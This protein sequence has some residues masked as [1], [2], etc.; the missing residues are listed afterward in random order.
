MQ[1]ANFQSSAF[2]ILPHSPPNDKDDYCHLKYKIFLGGKKTQTKI[3]LQRK[4]NVLAP[5]K[6]NPTRAGSIKKLF[7]LIFLEKK[8][9]F[10]PHK[11]IISFSL[12]MQE[13][14]VLSR[15]P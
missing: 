7:L 4:N 1:F 3:I 14:I 12:F 15:L 13:K 8:I 10:H 2:R 9:P 6:I 5:W 11:K